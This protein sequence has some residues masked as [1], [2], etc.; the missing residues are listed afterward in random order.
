MKNYT[1]F[2]I[3]QK[4]V[5][6]LVIVVI[7]FT[8]IIPKNVYADN[9]DGN[10][11][12]GGLLKEVVQLFAA[13]GDVVMG[14]LNKFM[15]GSDEFFSAMLD[16][17]DVNLEK[18]SGSW[19]TNGVWDLSNEELER[20]VVIPDDYMDD[21]TFLLDASTYKVPNMLYSPENIFANNIAAL[22]VNFLSPNNYTSVISGDETAMEA[23]ESAAGNLQ[24]TIA[25]WYRSFRNIAIVGL[26]SVLVYLGIRI[27]ISSTAADKAKYKESL[28][29]WFMALCLVF[30]IHFIMSGIL[31]LVDNFNALFSDEIN[32]GIV[33]EATHSDEGENA[34]ASFRF[35]TNLIGLARFRAQADQW[36]DATAYTIVYLA[37]VIYTCM[38]TFLYFKR[39]LWMAFFTMI[40]PLVAL[41]YPIDKAGDGH[42]QAFN[43][44]F[45]EYTMNAII[46]PVHL[47]LYSVF[48]SSAIDLATNNPIYAIVAIAFLIPAEKF[49]KKMF[50]LDQSQ[51]E[52]DFGSFAGGALTM[53]AMNSLSKLGS[54]INSKAKRRNSGGSSSDEDDGDNGRIMFAKRDDS[55]KLNSFNDGSTDSR[56]LPSGS[57]N[58]EDDQRENVRTTNN[59]GNGAENDE[60]NPYSYYG[61]YNNTYG[62]D[63]QRDNG[64]DEVD[65][66][67]E[68][69]ALGLNN[70]NPNGDGRD[71]EE[72]ELDRQRRLDKE[73][74]DQKERAKLFK[75]GWSRKEI[76]DYMA[77]SDTERKRAKRDKRVGKRLEKQGYSKDYINDYINRL[78]PPIKPA[79][80][81]RIAL[82]SAKTLGKGASFAGR[83]LVRATGMIGGATI[84]LAAGLTTGDMSKTFQY[85]AAGAVAGNVMG[86]NVN[87]LA[88]RAAN[89]AIS[90]PE[91]INRRIDNALD[92]WNTNLY[93]PSY[94]RQQRMDRQNRESRQ[95]MLSSETEREKAEQWMGENNYNGSVEDVINAKAD[96]M[97]AGVTDD[98]LM[99]DAMKT[100]FK[101]TGSLSG[102]NHQQYVDAAAFIKKQNYTK[103]TIEDEDKMRRMEERV[104]TMV[105]NPNDQLKVMQMTSQIL[106]ADKTYELRRREGRTRIGQPQQTPINNPQTNNTQTNNPPE[107]QGGGTPTPRPRGSGGNSPTPVPRGSGGN[108]PT[109][110]PSGNS[111]RSQTSSTQQIDRSISGGSGS[112]SSTPARQIQQESSQ[113]QQETPIKIIRKESQDRNNTTA[114]QKQQDTSIKYTQVRQKQQESSVEKRREIRKIGRQSIDNI[115]NSGRQNQGNSKKAGKQATPSQTGKRKPGRPRKNK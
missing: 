58:G 86:K 20:L 74:A 10:G 46:Q 40:A 82:K 102:G 85:A 55:D 63:T 38:F 71:V 112:G 11:I 72:S 4:I 92:D 80:V 37:L 42:A 115:D 66:D 39:F 22:D 75:Q 87:N 59:D 103:D 41:T 21:K 96:L 19:L 105:S 81:G 24:Y 25:S 64:S 16:Q 28:R 12:A 113:K 68:Y 47:I 29:D 8:C 26:L 70:N 5:I 52:G 100:E 36:Q 48:V 106:G 49:I 54:G 95:R 90:A 76:D 84:G 15:L 83:G 111:R 99:E 3:I 30:V 93:G 44:W 69:Y 18:D 45:K 9:D 34:N 14:A 104:Q 62:N 27:L 43:L 109:P 32:A 31:M 91:R 107:G 101:N 51:T 53:Q 110:V 50:R 114:K 89:A 108:S 79:G 57:E 56:P 73:K 77:L 35:R 67:D 6:A 61:A 7:L 97:E 17:D 98:K 88:S 33:V 94:A 2:K 1:K 65:N 13:L 78:P 23:S 60:N